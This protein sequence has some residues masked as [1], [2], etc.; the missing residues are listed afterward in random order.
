MRKTPGEV[1]AGAAF[2]RFSLAFY[3][4]PGVAEALLALQDAG[5]FD[6]NLILF[7][8]WL[9]LSGRGRLDGARLA[10]AEAAGRPLRTEIV[11][12]LRRLRRR[13]EP[14]P[15]ADF[16][17][18]RAAILAL[19]LE[20][21]RAVQERLAGGAGP[22]GGP[23]DLPARRADAQAN[24]QFYLGAEAAEQAEAAVVGRALA[25]FSVTDQAARAH[26]LPP[27]G[28]HAGSPQ[29]RTVPLSRPNKS[30]VR[31]RV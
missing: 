23:P 5:G 17:R 21:E 29:R 18:L 24:L 8:L 9:G 11:V 20:A 26:P 30:R 10:T 4:L 27:S 13:I 7:G 25:R 1:S 31:P 16:R 3:A 28:G 6:V 2:W 19:E 22:A 14:H 15:E 12:P